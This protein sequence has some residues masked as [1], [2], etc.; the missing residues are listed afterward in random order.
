MKNTTSIL[1]TIICLII[2][3]PASNAVSENNLR[4]P[5]IDGI[6][7][8]GPYYNEASKSYFELRRNNNSTWEEDALEAKSHIFK[9]TPGRLATIATPQTHSFLVSKFTFEEDTWLGLQFLCENST[10]EW[11]DGS[12][13]VSN[14]FSNWDMT[15]KIRN[16]NC[17]N[18][19]YING[20]IK[21]NS[22]NWLLGT[23]DKKSNFYLVEYPTG[24]K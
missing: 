2:V 23:S 1:L 13:P 24:K 3:I 7:S 4:L 20:Y 19:K 18:N 16:Y 5:S 15:L 22:F 8:A 6:F 14:N 11:S 12:A 17:E 21:K 10:F 9:K